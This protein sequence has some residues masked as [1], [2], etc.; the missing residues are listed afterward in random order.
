VGLADGDYP[1]SG[2]SGNDGCAASEVRQARERPDG[3]VRSFGICGI[4]MHQAI[5]A[6]SA[7]EGLAAGRS[8]PSFALFEVARER[9][10]VFD[11]EG[12][13]TS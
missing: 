13:R 4:G 6:R 7:S 10:S 2:V 11:P 1:A 3:E 12:V 8:D 5:L 9:R